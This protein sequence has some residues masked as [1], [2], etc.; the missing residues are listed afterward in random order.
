MALTIATAFR[1]RNKLKEKISKLTSL[2]NS[3]EMTK[4]VGEEENTAIFDGKTFRETI[5]AVSLLMETLRD[6]NLAIEKANVVNKE[7]LISLS[8]ESLKA[9]IAFYESVA[10][11]FRRIEKYSYEFNSSGGRDKFE[12]EPVLDQKAVVSRLEELKKKK[13]EIEERLADSNFKTPVEF[14]Q[15]RISKL[16]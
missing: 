13:D 2:T 7:D 6:F 4:K 10:G 3:A 15:A 12:L 16:L 11:K 14:D 8:L 9:E 1:L 5:T